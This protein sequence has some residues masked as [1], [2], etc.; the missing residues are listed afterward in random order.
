MKMYELLFKTLRYYNKNKISYKE[1][2][3]ILLS[4]INKPKEYLYAN[5]REK[6]SNKVK[7]IFL[8][9]IRKRINGIPLQYL[10]N[11]EFFYGR[12]FL[13]KKGVFIPRPETE[14]LIEA[15]KKIN[16]KNNCSCLDI[17]CGSGCIGI[18][19][20]LELP[21][22]KDITFIDKNKTAIKITK[23]NI[24]IHKINGNV[25]NLCFFKYIK[26]NKTKYDIAACNP[27]YIS[28]D[29]FNNLQEEVKNEPK[30][31]LL[32]KKNGY[33]F[34]IRLA[35]SG[36]NFLKNNGFLI[37]EAGINM[38]ENIKKIFNKNWSFLFS[39]NDFNNIERALVFQLRF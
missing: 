31:A 34:Y 27:P 29:L 9:K 21:Y 13:V 36:K 17:G 20:K 28:Y 2:E 23:Q 22:I 15:V 19:L 1:A 18:T 12:K 35:D 5:F 26:K 39:I 8:N 30:S 24:N 14:T 4:I 37:L 33:D 32:A 38:A 11:F 6:I 7:N 3:T 10:T 25:I 16:I